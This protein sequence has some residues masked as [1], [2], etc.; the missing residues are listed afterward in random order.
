MRRWTAGFGVALA[1]A[2]GT[3][4]SAPPAGA[5]SHCS[6]YFIDTEKV[7]ARCTSSAGAM[8]KVFAI[9]YC[10][11]DLTPQRIVYGRAVPVHETSVADCGGGWYAADRA[12]AT[13]S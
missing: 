2:G 3:A 13:R 4:F 6:S 5:I 11:R 7:E 1:I 12:Y 8:T 9:A 10:R